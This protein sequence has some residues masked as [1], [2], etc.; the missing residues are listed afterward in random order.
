MRRDSIIRWAMILR[1]CVIGTRSPGIVAAGAG[2]RG[3]GVGGEA[4]D[5]AATG[6]LAVCGFSKNAMMSCFVMRPPMPVPGT[7][8]RF[9]SCSR[10]ILRTK[11]EER[12]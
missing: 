9:M 11:G 6:A 12:A 8:D 3:D 4:E 10:A 2:D 1:I 7:C 5:G